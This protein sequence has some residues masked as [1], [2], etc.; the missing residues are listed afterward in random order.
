MSDAVGAIAS[1][2]SE[3]TLGTTYTD[4]LGIASDKDYFQLP[5][6]SKNSKVTIDFTGLSSSTN[7]LLNGTT[8]EFKISI[9]N[10]SDAIIATTTRGISNTAADLTA[11][12]AANTTYYV[13][14]EKGTAYSNKN[15]SIKASMVETMETEANENVG[16]ADPI[17][18]NAA[19]TGYLGTSSAAKADDVD[20]YAFTT[21]TTSG[22]TV[23]ITIA[24]TAKDATFYKAKI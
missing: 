24:S 15:Y 23:A 14:V 12:L 5:Q 22:K 9:R 6:Q 3:L 8:G 19:F 16:T 4:N 20:V 13:S 18:P 17:V 21:G 10:S 11:S 1:N 2:P 7:D